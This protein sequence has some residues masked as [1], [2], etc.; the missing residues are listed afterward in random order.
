MAFMDRLSVSGKKVVVTGAAQGIGRCVADALAECGAD[1]GL[2][3]VN[4]AKLS[5]A[6]AAL[7]QKHGRRF[8][9][10]VCDVTDPARVERVFAAFGAPDAVFNN[11]GIVIHKPAEE[12]TPEEWRRVVDVDLNGVFYVAQ[13]AARLMIAAGRGGSIVNMASMS[14]VIVN[15]PQCQSSYNAAK[16]AVVHLS[17]SLAVEW[18][19]KGIRVNALSPGYIETEMTGAVNPQWRAFW[20]GLIPMGR[21]G[22]PEELAGAVIYLMSDAASYTTGLNLVVDGAFTCI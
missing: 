15:V 16:A 12:L 4:A 13:A 1:V 5:D 21:M 11:A 3:D 18:A 17:K 9:E 7:S 20:T 6:A 14:G 2:L 10:M 22:R 19:G 8:P